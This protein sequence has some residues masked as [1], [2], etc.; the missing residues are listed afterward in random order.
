MCSSTRGGE[1]RAGSAS[2]STNRAGE[3]PRSASRSRSPTCAPRGEP[4]A[5]AAARRRTPGSTPA[6]P[7][8]GGWQCSGGTEGGGLGLLPTTPSGGVAP[9]LSRRK[10]RSARALSAPDPLQST[11]QHHVPHPRQQRGSRSLPPGAPPALASGCRP[12]AA[13]P[14]STGR[15]GHHRRRGAGSRRR[16]VHHRRR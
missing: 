3:P 12:C 1:R 11:A 5:R 9:A 7:P 15:R 2:S 6:E 14:T 16:R 10:R 4:R 8:S 13:A